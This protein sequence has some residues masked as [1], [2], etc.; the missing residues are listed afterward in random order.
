M[1][2]AKKWD[3]KSPINGVAA[4]VVLNAN[5]S[6]KESNIYLI[7]NDGRVERMEN[8]ATIRNNTKLEGTD[9]E[10]IQRYLESIEN[11]ALLMSREELIKALEGKIN[12]RVNNQILS[13]FVWH[14]FPVW[15]SAEN[16]AN[17]KAAYDLAFQAQMIQTEFTHVKFKFG[18]DENVIYHTF[19]SFEEF[20]DFYVS[21]VTYI[22]T[23]YESGWDEK[24][25]LKSLADEDLRKL[26]NEQS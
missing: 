6:F 21:A 10:V 11:P 13:G 23:C 9:K 2:T 22:Q 17:Y 4:E 15:L 12:D 1:R 7:L 8:V 19:T 5:P 18:T 3:K 26:L 25:A 20:A 16:Q 24:D 14:D